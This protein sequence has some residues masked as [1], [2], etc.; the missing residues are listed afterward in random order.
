MC[1]ACYTPL[2][3]AATGAAP[4]GAGPAGAAKG[5]APA[6]VGDDGEKKK[7]PPW[8]LGVIGVGLLAAIYVGARSV[9]PPSGGDDE[10]GAE[11]P[12][13]AAPKTDEGGGAEPA[14]A[15]AAPTAANPVVI[16]SS[17]T[18]AVMPD[19]APF[20]IVVPPN[21]RIS[22][23]TM[24]IVPTEDGTSGPQAA[25]LAAYTRRQYTAHLKSWSTLYVYVFSDQ[26]SAE[27]F[28]E[29]QKRRRGAPLAHSDYSQLSNLWTTCL[30]RYEYSAAGGGKRVE[31]VLY[32]SKNPNGWWYSRNN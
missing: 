29:Y 11:T 8:Q 23:A 19:K 6:A 1:W 13:E 9:M 22:V 24:A 14:P 27:Y 28:A 12:A 31:R 7:I 3:G 5:A 17:G 2:A 4:A 25:A 15:P 10:D 16:S 32:P 20:T 26:K 21:P 18:A 30:A